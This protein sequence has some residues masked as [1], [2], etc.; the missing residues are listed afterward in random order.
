MKIR[1]ADYIADFV[2]YTV[3]TE[4]IFSITG[5]G[6]MFLNDAF[7]NHKTIKPIYNHH[8]Q[9][10]AMGALG[11]SKYSG[12]VGVACLTTGCGCTHSLT[13]VLDGWQD[14]TPM[15]MI[16]GQVK[17]KETTYNTDVPLR[18]FGVQEANI[19]AIVKNITKYAVMVNEPNEIAYHL[20]KALYLA[21]NGRPGPVW[22]DVPLDVQGATIE[23]D[24]LV[25]FDATKE[26]LEKKPPIPSDAINSFVDMLSQAKRPVVIAGNGVRLSKT[27][28]QFKDFV[29]KHNLPST[30]TYLSIDLLESEHPLAVGRLGTKG[31]RAGNFAVANAD[32]VISLGCRLS[33]PVTGFEYDLFAR[34]AKVVV[35]DIDT[36]EHNKNTVNIDLMIHAD[37]TDFFTQVSMS[38][39]APEGWVQQCLHWR[40]KWPVYQTEYASEPTVNLYQFLH[41]LKDVAPVDSVTVS[42][43]GSSY[44]V[45]SQALQIK[46]EQRYITSGAQADMGFS[47]PAAIGACLAKGNKDVFA[48]TG[49]GS[50][51]QNIQ[52]L[53]TIMHNQLPVKIFVWNNSGYLSNR[54]TQ[55]KFFEQRFA[56]AGPQSG[57]SFPPFEKIAYA[58]DMPYVCIDNPND[59]DSGL[60]QVMDKKGPV[61]C[62]VICTENQEIIPAAS[63]LK[64]QDGTMVSK[65]LEDMYPFLERDEFLSEMIIKPVDEG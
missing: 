30:F 31:D 50:F 35:V 28:K 22:I 37:L 20:Q 3:K 15:L 47:I 9:A 65:P 56:G 52:E 11:Y 64:R 40:Q 5:G 25:H 32:L 8:E 6:A 23:T 19:I 36:D 61:L 59:L 57:V 17:R 53:Q 14:N 27:E 21:T 10:C 60:K 26:G 41:I 34:D 12:G 49:D 54:I 29:E 62:E 51:Q 4:T 63:S 48:I 13:G 7:G 55:T 2:A 39:E 18:Q 43:A 45:T 38:Y 33:V 46:G 24:D 58:Y 42:D 1:V 16:S 44:F